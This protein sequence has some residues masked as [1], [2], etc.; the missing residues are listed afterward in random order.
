MATI[1]LMESTYPIEGPD[2]SSYQDYN[3]QSRFIGINFKK[4]R[5]TRP[6]VRFML[7]KLG[8]GAS[9]YYPLKVGLAQLQEGYEA[10]F[11]IV[12][13]YHFYHFDVPVLDQVNYFKGRVG[14]MVFKPHRVM[15]DVEDDD[16]ETSRPPRHALEPAEYP[17]WIQKA[18]RILGHL[19]TYLNAFANE[20]NGLL[21]YGADWYQGWF[22]WLGEMDGV[23]IS[24]MKQ[25][26][27]HC[28]SYTRPSMYIPYGIS[29]KQIKLWQWESTIPVD[30]QLA[31]MPDPSR[32][33]MNYWVGDPTDYPAWAGINSA[34]TPATTAAPYKV[35]APLIT[36]HARIQGYTG[37]DPDIT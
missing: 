36:N 2:I 14:K 1:T 30:K 29:R 4:M 10:G 35:W 18:R 5:A 32:V 31:G 13:P 17:E 24:F 8:E 33:D 22:T 11:D 20:F 15:V 3:A 19:K 34:P 16:N 23:D 7:A 26:D 37:P 28:A 9:D 27:F 12:V 6:S 21:W 25:Y